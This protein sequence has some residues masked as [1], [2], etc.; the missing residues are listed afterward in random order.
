MKASNANEKKKLAIIGVLGLLLLGVGAFQIIGG[1]GSAPA[2]E[3]KKD[4]PSVA[5]GT[6]TE[7]DPGNAEDSGEGDLIAGKLPQRDPFLAPG[8]VQTNSPTGATTGTPTMPSANPTTT[9][10]NQPVGYQSTEN[11]PMPPMPGDIQPMP[12]VHEG[13]PG[14][15]TGLGDSNQPEA[16]S[17]KLTGVVLGDTAL[18]VIQD[19]SGKQRV[20]RVGDTVSGHRVVSITKNKVVLSGSGERVTLAINSDAKE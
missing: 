2:P 12:N 17:L 4:K 7:S 6:G 9:A 13:N 19:E 16:P 10:S 20:L 14:E 1:G 8:A 15:N 5:A 18:A 11:P 3:A